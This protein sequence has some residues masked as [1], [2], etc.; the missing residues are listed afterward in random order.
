MT[1]NERE[2]F[3]KKATSSFVFLSG[4]P[5]FLVILSVIID[6]IPR[7]LQ[8][9]SISYLMTGN[10]WVPPDRSWAYGFAVHWL[11][12]ATKTFG[13]YIVIN[14]VLLLC[15]VYSCRA[16]FSNRSF[17]EKLFLFLAILLSMDPLLAIYTRFYLSDIFGLAFFVAFVHSFGVYLSRAN[18]PWWN[19]LILV[20]CAIGA[21]FIRLAY[22][23]II[24]VLVFIVLLWTCIHATAQVRWRAMVALIIPVLAVAT[25]A[26]ANMELFADKYGHKP[27][28]NKLSGTFLMGVFA[29]A[30]SEKDFRKAGIPI[31][32]EEYYNLD[33]LSFD[34]RGRQVWGLTMAS[35][36]PLIKSRLGI[37]GDYDATVDHTCFQIVVNAFQRKPMAILRVYARSLYYYFVYDEWKKSLESEM[38]SDRQLDPSFVEYLNSMTF[39]KISP[40]ASYQRSVWQIIY[41]SFLPFY[42]VYLLICIFVSFYY[43]LINK[44]NLII[45]IVSSAFI[46]PI[47]ATP[48]YGYYVIP[49]YVIASVFMGYLLLALTVRDFTALRQSGPVSRRVALPTVS[50]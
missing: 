32:D 16:Y 39:A 43:I 17:D 5:T 44:K 27:F 40:D 49:R 1:L 7:F 3:T 41:K 33:S 47:V 38:G 11:L 50:L 22:A 19:I 18:F 45:V 30:L 4:I 46:A 25:L 28:V 13:S 37:K 29:P 21:V 6:Q 42:P 24:G 23:P 8:G 12:D 48:L 34:Q 14:N 9:D 35:A 20:A 10:G 15:M 36:L 26:A 2:A 31:S